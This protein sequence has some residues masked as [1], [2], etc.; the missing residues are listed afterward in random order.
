MCTCFSLVK[1]L[2]GLTFGGVFSFYNMCGFAG[3]RVWFNIACLIGFFYW[4]YANMFYW[5]YFTDYFGF[6]IC[7]RLDFRFDFVNSY[8][9]C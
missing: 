2:P 7:L 1:T 9:C 5:E 6:F 3:A 8:I 4:K